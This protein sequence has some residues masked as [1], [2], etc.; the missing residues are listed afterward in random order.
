MHSV[1][2]DRINRL[3]EQRIGG[4]PDEAEIGAAGVEARKAIRALDTGPLGHVTLV[5]CS[6]I[7]PV[8]DAVI[9]AAFAQ[10]NDPRFSC[11]RA[12]KVAMILPSALARMKV[13]PPS[14]S[15]DNMALFSSR[16]DAMRW[17]FDRAPTAKAPAATAR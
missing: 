13:S 3:V 6:D 8:T 1:R 11:V 5:D 17:L 7:G 16:D 2:I 14:K 4:I 15:R 9:A 12:R 10:W